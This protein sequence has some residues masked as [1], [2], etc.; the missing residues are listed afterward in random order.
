M[1]R[2]VDHLCLTSEKSISALHCSR[3]QLLLLSIE[4]IHLINAL[5]YG[6]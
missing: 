3:G 2:L 1:I 5:V 4:T 6:F